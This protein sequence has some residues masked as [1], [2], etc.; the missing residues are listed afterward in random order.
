M[1]ISTN[2][3]FLDRMV[4]YEKAVEIIGRVGFDAWDLSLFNLELDDNP[5]LCSDYVKRVK[6]LRKI[7]EDFGMTCNQSHTPFSPKFN[8]DVFDMQRKAIECT[9]IAG[10]EIAV[11]HPVN[12]YSAQQ[13]AELYFKL[14]PFAKEHGVKIA[15]E[16][17]WNWNTEKDIASKA[18]CSH[19]LDFKAHIDA[20][21]D[22][23]LVACL[24]I[25]HAQ[26]QGL[27]TS[28]VLMIESL[29]NSLQ[30][31]HI[32]DNDCHYD[33]HA[34]P[35]T[36]KIEFESIVKA[37]KNANYKGYF[38]MES[39]RHLNFFTAETAEKGI[40]EIY[41]VAKRLADMFENF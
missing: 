5:M 1:K 26:M 14:L 29:G 24:D 6:N 4:G 2:T 7:G 27:D 38:T 33:S 30:A 10:G 12:D 36:G 22:P 39:E 17:M 23:Y 37:L 13:N 11:V 20:V 40:K 28:A 32:H 19:H 8:Q 21:C 25:G 41:L 31:L 16:N 15:T 34:L 35:F 3:N 9:A 18:A